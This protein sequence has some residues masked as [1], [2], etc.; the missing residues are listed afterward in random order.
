MISPPFQYKYD[1]LAGV[2]LFS[3]VL[4]TS[5]VF[6]Q[7]ELTFKAFIGCWA[8]EK[9]MCHTPMCIKQSSINLFDEVQ[10]AITKR[11]QVGKPNAWRLDLRCRTVDQGI[12]VRQNLLILDSEGN[13]YDYSRG[14]VGRWIK[15]LNR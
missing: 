7:T 3:C 6:A 4:F 5:T 1:L 14:R 12:D 8:V 11:V 2:V 13:L 15:C 10:C 9:N